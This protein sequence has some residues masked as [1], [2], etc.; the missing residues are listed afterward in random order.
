MVASTKSQLWRLSLLAL[1]FAQQSVFALLNIDGNRNQVFI[2]GGATLAYDS[3]IFAQRNGSSDTTETLNL[4]TNLKRNAGLITVDGT[5]SVDFLRYN[6]NTNFNAT[7]PNLHVVF[8]KAAGRLTGSFTIDAFRSQQADTAVNLR[9]SSWNFPVGLNLRYPLNEKFYATSQSSFVKRDFVDN[10]T[11]LQNYRDFS[12]AVDGY[13]VYTSKLDLLA[14]Y[15]VRFSRTALERS[16][17]HDFY[18]GATGALLAKAT[19]LVRVG[20][21]V[22]QPEGGGTSYGQ[23][24]ALA[25]V[26]WNVSRKL[27][28]TLEISRDFSTTATSVSVDALTTALNGTYAMTRRFE[29]NGSLAYGRNRF[30]G[31]GG[32]GRHDDFSSF[33][34]GLS[35]GLNDNVKV[36]S[37]YTY[38]RNLSTLDEAEFDRQQFSVTV[39]GRY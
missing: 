8:E 21:Q 27:S 34:L 6:H 17:D 32:D 19:G 1:L 22:R 16:T 15:R 9:T 11:G 29:L 4:G 31:A 26:T 28:T 2:F 38:F 39:S 36:L 18:L 13:Y 3:N 12:E 7:N 24:S 20:Y 37:S 25:Q 5:L 10:N 14:G 33:T 35:Y 30:L 23:L